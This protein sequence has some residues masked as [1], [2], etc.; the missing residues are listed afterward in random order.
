MFITL[1]SLVTASLP[2]NTKSISFMKCLAALST[3]M[4]VSTPASTSSRAVI[5]PWYLGRVSVCIT[6]NLLPDSWALRRVSVTALL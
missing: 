6:R 1:P 4:V 3:I 2:T 5:L